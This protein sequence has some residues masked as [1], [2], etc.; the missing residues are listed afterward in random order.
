MVGLVDRLC[1]AQGPKALRAELACLA[2]SG[3]AHVIVD[4]VAN[5]DL[6][7]IAEACR[8]MV[9]VTGGSA[10]A[11]PLPAFYRA[12]GH[13]GLDVGGPEVPD[14]QRAAIL[15]SGS[16]SAMTQAQ[17]AQYV[18][19]GAPALRLYPLTLAWTG[20]GPALDWLA[21]QDLNHAPIIYATAE[22][23]SVRAAQDILGRDRSGKIVESA[24]AACAVAARN[25][26]ARRI[27]VAEDETSGAVTTA[28]QVDRL[29]IGREI[30]PGVP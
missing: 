8:D 3:G 9:L 27:V 10:L 5:D 21:A 23:A 26:G 14:L 13:L 6:A 19:S 16:C 24:L 17:V 18:A 25:A 30:A 12:T 28:L 22:P 7:V 29:H 15:L 2:T 11:M 4:A 1:V 20:P